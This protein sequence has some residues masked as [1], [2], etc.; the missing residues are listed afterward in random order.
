MTTKQESV[1]S[2]MSQAKV[3]S[4]PPK[5]FTCDWFAAKRSVEHLYKLNPETAA[6]G[7]GMPMR[8]FELQSALS[9]LTTHFNQMA[10]PEHGRYV[11]APAIA[12]ANG[13]VYVP[14]APDSNHMMLKAFG[15]SAVLAAGLVYA[16]YRK[17]RTQ[18]YNDTMMDVEY[19]Y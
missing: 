6:T 4:G 17:N 1:L 13:V 11:P 9:E 7:H 14:P 12:N 19:N 16:N 8:G 15:V 3:L 5:Y 10:V 18:A 2:V